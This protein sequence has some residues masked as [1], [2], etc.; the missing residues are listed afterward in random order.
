[1]PRTM[2]I[3]DRKDAS[4]KTVNIPCSTGKGEN[5][6]GSDFPAELPTSLADAIG[7]Y[8]EEDVFKRFLNAQVVHLQGKERNKL[9]GDAK[10][11]KRA[12]Y[13]ETLGL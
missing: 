11:R 8:G 6:K 10:P 7:F 1:M 9:S 12:S 4:V 5:K 13:Y 3:P 2:E